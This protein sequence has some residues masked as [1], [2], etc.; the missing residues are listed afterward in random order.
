MLTPEIAKNQIN[1]HFETIKNSIDLDY[2]KNVNNIFLNHLL[3]KKG[4]IS[5]NDPISIYVSLEMDKKLKIDL[6][7]EKIQKEKAIEFH[8]F[9]EVKR[10]YETLK[11][12]DYEYSYQM[13]V[14]RAFS[15][16]GPLSLYNCGN[17]AIYYK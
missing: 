14:Q 9:K 17:G 5:N 16:P 1:K 15:M 6:E 4:L 11:K 8:Y 3:I 7:N 2:L 12:T 10:F 13:E